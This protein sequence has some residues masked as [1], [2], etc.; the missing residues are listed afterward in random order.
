MAAESAH[1][2]GNTGPDTAASQESN[3]DLHRDDVVVRLALKCGRRG[4][5]PHVALGVLAAQ[6]T[7]HTRRKHAEM[8]SVARVNS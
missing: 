6:G 3:T 7:Q 5:E 4:Q 8:H 2:S 1:T